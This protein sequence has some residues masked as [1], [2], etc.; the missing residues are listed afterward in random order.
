MRSGPAIK[1]TRI[2]ESGE[3]EEQKTWSDQTINEGQKASD[4]ARSASVLSSVL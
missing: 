4:V 1:C 3:V 2:Y